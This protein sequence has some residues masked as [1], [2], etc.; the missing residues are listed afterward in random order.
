MQPISDL[1]E[2]KI[3]E[4]NIMKHIHTFCLDNNISYFLCFGTLIGAVRHHGFIPWDDDIDIVMPREDY[5]R[6]LNTF[7]TYAELHNL[8]I[9][10]NRTKIYYG[11]P[12]SKVIDT[13]TILKETDYWCDDD[14]GV[15]VDIWAMDGVPDG[16]NQ[17]KWLKL[18]RRKKN[19]LFA[20][21]L[22]YNKK[23]GAKNV[24]VFFGRF[25]NQRK[26]AK[27]FDEF[28]QKYK[29]AE[30]DKV[31]CYMNIKPMAY[32][33]EWF[34]DKVLLEFEDQHFFAPIGYDEWLKQIFGDYMK[35]PPVSQQ[36][37]HHVSN[38]FWK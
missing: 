8:A 3:I 38:V 17:D 5:E 6:F 21:S 13:R 10:N 20:S 26:A 29:Y 22:N 19:I 27:Q 24:A 25:I 4:L 11:R 31:C 7:P 36:I 2:L 9:V 32:D 16:K 14:I 12:M 33:K 37:P 15:F 23:L 30:C 34:K 28:A 18:M 1:N 35:L